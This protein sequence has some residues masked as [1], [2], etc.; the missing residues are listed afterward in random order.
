MVGRWGM[1]KAIGP[2]ALLPDDGRGPL[3]A[4]R[5]ETSEQTRQ[6]V[7]AEVR[8]IVTEALDEVTELL[9]RHRHQLDALASA[10]MEHETLD[11]A[12]AYAAAQIG[13]SRN[14]GAPP[15]PRAAQR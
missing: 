2:L 7:D 8:R 6:A 13:G 5:D 12:E 10:L 14:G 15:A 4:R 3:P 1:S 11:E 9:R